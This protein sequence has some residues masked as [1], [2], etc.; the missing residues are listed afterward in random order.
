MNDL[1]SWNNLSS[2][3]FRG[4]VD[5]LRSLSDLI[6]WEPAAF[7]DASPRIIAQQSVLVLVHPQGPSTRLAGTISIDK[8]DK[9]DLLHQLRDLGIGEDTLF[10]DVQGFAKSNSPSATLRGGTFSARTLLDT[11]NLQFSRR[12]IDGAIATYTRLINEFADT[13]DIRFLLANAYAESKMHAQAIGEYDQS[14]IRR[15]ELTRVSVA[16]I[17]FNRGNCNAGMSKHE[18][19]LADYSDAIALRSPFRRAHFNRANSYFAL[20]EFEKAIADYGCAPNCL[21]TE[22][23]QGNT[24]MALGQFKP[25]LECYESALKF[26]EE[27][28]Q[29]ANNLAHARE[30]ICLLNGADT[31]HR[32]ILQ[33]AG[34]LR[35][36]Q[37][38]LPGYANPELFDMQPILI[39]HNHYY[40]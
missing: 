14:L 20:G 2:A 9:P 31:L 27:S 32:G 40:V 25:A 29:I 6:S 21:Q 4:A 26:G 36:S 13:D 15:D 19:A 3:T 12:D 33:R 30:I 23:N 22:Y 8:N 18:S 7:G 1:N 35:S 39:R 37:I 10:V 34:S 24:Y 5:S 28:V 11:A 17:N 16:A 38:G